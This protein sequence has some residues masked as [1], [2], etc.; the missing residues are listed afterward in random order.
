MSKIAAIYCR[1]STHKQDADR[2]IRDLLAF[3]QRADYLVDPIHVFVETETGKETGKVRP[4]RA[5]V[6]Q[7]ARERKIEA[8]LVTEMSRWGRSLPDLIT[9]LDN[10]ATWGC[11][12]VAQ[13]GFDF[14][15]G[16]AQGRL[17]VGILGSL[18][19][20][21]RE[22]LRERTI[23]GLEAAKARGKKLGRQTGHC[24]SDK[25]APLVR[26]MLAGGMTIRAVAEEIGISPMTVQG[27][28]KRT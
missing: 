13:T 6:I 10:L 3:A 11:S 23:S 15:M 28:K 25:H 8:I 16:T 26:K 17:M 5:Q 9:T 18:A 20:F 4:I 1:V 14:D 21:E 7:L 24:P 12:L 19:E 27:I 22:L 2:Q